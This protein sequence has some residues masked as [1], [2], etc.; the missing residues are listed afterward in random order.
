MN[1][2]LL[3]RQYGAVISQPRISPVTWSA[4]LVTVALAM[5]GLG[6]SI[7]T[8]FQLAS[9]PNIIY[10]IFYIITLDV[11]TLLVRQTRIVRAVQSALFGVL[12]LATTCVFGI[13]AAYS[14]QRL[15][16][17]L[18]DDFLGN[19]DRALGFNWLA[20]AR[21]VDSHVFV[22]TVF[23]TAYDTIF[24]QIVLAV[25]VLAFSSRPEELRTF[26]LAMAIAFIFTIIISAL[27]PAAGPIVFADRSSFSVLQ[28]TGATPIDHLLRLREAGP[29]V[30]TDHP[31]GIATFPS[32]HTTVAVL[33][34]L[35][36]RGFPP[37]FAALVI[38]DAAMLGGTLSEGAHYLTDVLAGAWM[39]FFGYAMARR[40]MPL[41]EALI[42]R[43][44]SAWLVSR[45]TKSGSAAGDA[46]LVGGNLKDH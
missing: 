35:T 40:I 31:G 34:P 27:V 41:E 25:V 24:P 12:Y 42:A 33:V 19:A 1:L 21:W 13:L 10:L 30:M 9:L 45:S 44:R 3:R 7:A 6:A 23:H 17:P 20:F 37:V 11:L 26:L 14:I 2:G 39:A 5:I 38:L 22:Q 32:F 16:F 43:Y 46:A 15:G 36:L 4:M 29:L 18:R 8:K 28:F